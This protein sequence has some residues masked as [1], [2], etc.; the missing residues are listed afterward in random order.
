MQPRGA[1]A[2]ACLGLAGCAGSSL[3]LLPDEDGGQGEVAVLES[4]GR[5]QDTVIAQGNSR[6]RLGARPRTRPIG[7][8]AKR[9]R[10]IIDNLPAAPLS[11]TLYF[12]EGGTRLTSE[13]QP[14]L[15]ALLGDVA[16][17]PG[18]DVQ[19]TGHTDRLGQGEDN[20]RLSLERARE[21]RDLLIAQ[22]LPADIVSAVGRGEREPSVATADG[23]RN[24]QNR[25]VEVIVR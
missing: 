21:I 23:V 13:S 25:R 1:L 4:G 17:R 9:D 11:Y 19:V 10:A 14:Q 5:Q 6:T 12:I 3:V 2:A 7:E 18:P 15:A 22:G 24:P 16:R 8:L 20:D